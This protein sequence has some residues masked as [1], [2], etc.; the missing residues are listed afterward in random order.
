ME[1]SNI[2]IYIIITVG[3]E[4][5]NTKLKK[6]SKEFLNCE[7]WLDSDVS[8]FKK[9]GGNISVNKI[10]EA[11]LPTYY[12]RPWSGSSC[13]DIIRHTYIASKY[14]YQEFKVGA[15]AR[16]VQTPFACSFKSGILL[17]KLRD[18]TV[19]CERFFELSIERN[20]LRYYVKLDT[21]KPKESINIE[22]M[23]MTFF[24]QKEFDVPSNT[25]LVQFVQ[26]SAT[27]HMF[28]RTDDS[29]SIINWYNV[30]RLAKY[31][32]FCVNLSGMGIDI[33]TTSIYDTLTTSL[34]FAGWLVK[35]GPRKTDFSHRRWCMLF[36]R[37]FLY[38]ENPLSAFA[39]GELFIG[40]N[41]EGYS[42]SECCSENLNEFSFTLQTPKRN[43]TF[44][45]ETEE[46]YNNWVSKLNHV[47]HNPLTPNDHKQAIRVKSKR[48]DNFDFF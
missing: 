8:C 24:T 18:S 37:H 38:T 16:G 30:V 45:L 29:K 40:S 27:R 48:T 15:I 10:Y 43:F 14:F 11:E 4:L 47:I 28:I 31:H 41:D 35:T 23:N 5:I 25:A 13:P 7:D 36:N 12:H 1:V 42:I 32:R 44:I 46:E 19:F 9:F 6:L 22:K 26:D 33:Y 34:D 17:K 3:H 2:I 20:V 21:S 39:K